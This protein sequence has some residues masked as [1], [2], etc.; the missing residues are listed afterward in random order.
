M[1]R[2][3]RGGAAEECGHAPEDG[4]ASEPGRAELEG[5][6]GCGA[7]R[8]GH[9]G[10]REAVRGLEALHG[11]VDEGCGEVRA[12]GWCL[13]RSPLRRCGGRRCDGGGHRAAWLGG[14]RGEHVLPRRQ[15]L[16]PALLAAV[17]QHPGHDRE[18]G[19]PLRAAPPPD[20]AAAHRVAAGAREARARV[21]EGGCGAPPAAAVAVGSL[22]EG[23]RGCKRHHRSGRSAVGAWCS[24]SWPE[25]VKAR[26]RV[27]GTCQ[28]TAQRQPLITSPTLE[29]LRCETWRMYLTATEPP[30]SMQYPRKKTL[31]ADTLNF[32]KA[33]SVLL[34][35]AARK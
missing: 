18:E 34:M 28:S 32:G 10:E 5:A 15:G 23:Q 31:L 20:L 21:V 27:M 2:E 1:G 17:P 35:G 6:D 29:R 25:S 3:P 12:G 33:R 13:P 7:R 30:V 4:K 24:P 22:P 8:V 9:E 16:A 26:H 11:V 19:R 14:L